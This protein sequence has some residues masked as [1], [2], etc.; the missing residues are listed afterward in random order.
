MKTSTGSNSSC[1]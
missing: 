1:S